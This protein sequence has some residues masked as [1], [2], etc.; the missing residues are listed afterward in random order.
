MAEPT[1]RDLLAGSGLIIAAGNMPAMAA[2]DPEAGQTAA[3]LD[4]YIGFGI[5]A[6]GGPGDN[7]SGAWI[8]DRLR[9]AG[10][11]VDR[12]PFDAPYFEIVRAELSA[13]SA[14]APVIPQAIVIPTG[15][16]GVTG[17]LVRVDPIAGASS[18]LTNAIALVDLPYN[19]WSS[20][21]AKPIMDTVRAAL[22]GGAVAAVITTNGPTRKAIALNAD[23]KA[24]MFDKPV[25]VLAPDQAAPFLVAAAKR[26]SA[27]LRVT[28]TAGR[29]SAYNL[30]G[31]I[32]RGKGRWIVLST[33][34]SGWFTCA[35][36]RGPGIAAWL[37][38]ARWAPAALPDHDI[39][40]LCNSGHEYEY[41]GAEKAL[42]A[43]APP[44]AD[45]AF[46]LHLGANVAA[47]DWQEMGGGM[48]LP[49]P[50]ADPQR[51]LV[52]SPA[53][54]EQARRAFAGQPGLESAY[55]AGQGSAGELTNIL[56]A[57]YGRVAG[58][59]G[60]HRFHH[61]A[62]DDSS[63]V[64]PLLVDRAIAACKQLIIASVG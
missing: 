21:L 60:A 29:R 22:A 58:I 10:Y 51:F 45:T 1:R 50:S 41:L 54:V 49:L 64:S 27:T 38:L 7:A 28:G 48:L 53:L 37:A 46:W 33:P 42:A 56:A 34:R 3:D 9:R 44:P 6:S 32:D 4:R 40:L 23:G 2:S 47:R 20:A 57:G 12:Q 55:P 8:E 5:K 17:R 63:C 62:G 31:K 11:K 25:A 16:D 52:T 36:E 59:F 43:L 13:G 19:R 15:G 30:I 35:G 18:V 24:P 61:V 14:T 39:A 26:E